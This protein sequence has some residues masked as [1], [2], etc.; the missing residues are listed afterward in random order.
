[1]CEIEYGIPK[2]NNKKMIFDEDIK[3]LV[4]TE[5]WIMKRMDKLDL[6]Q[7]TS[8][9]LNSSDYSVIGESAD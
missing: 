5:K 4:Q 8:T 6:V 1:M 7:N 9:S 3:E 2:N